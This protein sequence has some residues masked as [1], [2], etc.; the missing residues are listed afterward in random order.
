MF[1]LKKKRKNTVQDN[2]ETTN[3]VTP[4]TS[5]EPDLTDIKPVT[6][7]VSIRNWILN[8]EGFFSYD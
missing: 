4:L 5:E 7:T 1:E 3:F 8:L 2:N 6:N